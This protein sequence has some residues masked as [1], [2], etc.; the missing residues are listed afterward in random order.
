MRNP[1]RTRTV[2][3][4]ALIALLGF[5]AAQPLANPLSPRDP[6]A[7]WP[8]WELVDFQPKSPKYNQKYGLDH[9]KGRI[10]MVAL[11]AHGVLTAKNKSPRWRSWKRTSRPTASRSIS[12]R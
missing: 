1:N 5:K 3:A 9:F 10:T 11:L 6:G 8:G 7:L 2:L 12:S 4:L